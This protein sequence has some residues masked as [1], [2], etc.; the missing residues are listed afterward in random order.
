M[1]RSSF[2]ALCTQ[3]KSAR[4][5]PSCFSAIIIVVLHVPL[6]GGPE[7]VEHQ[8][9]MDE[10]AL[11]AEEAPPVAVGGERAR[12]GQR[13][14]T[15]GRF[16]A[17]S[18]IV[19]RAHVDVGERAIGSYGIVCR[20]HINEGDPRPGRC[21]KTL[22]LNATLSAEQAKVQLKRWVLEGARRTLENEAFS[23]DDHR[24]IDARHLPGLSGRALDT[25]LTEIEEALAERNLL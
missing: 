21:K 2:W 12:P 19:Q 14:A 10:W 20:L 24:N 13:V 16:W 1:P 25:A 23:R 11:V 7:D 6:Q 5:T 9:L 18:S 8:R 22:G 15:T 3:K 17:L 4:L